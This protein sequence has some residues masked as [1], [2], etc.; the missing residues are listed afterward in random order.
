M[1]EYDI[2]GLLM[3][4]SSQ[5]CEREDNVIT[6]DLRGICYWK[7]ITFGKA[8]LIRNR[9][10]G[11]FLENKAPK[12]WEFCIRSS[13]FSKNT[14]HGIWKA[15]VSKT[16]SNVLERNKYIHSSG[17]VFGPLEFSRRD[18]MAL[19]IQRGRDHGLPDYNTVREAYGLDRIEK[20]TDINPNLA[21]QKPGVSVV[22]QRFFC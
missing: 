22:T 10:K 2:D 17:D 7:L 11:G 4:M 3:G 18:L 12:H 19:N 14:K 21:F 5:V 6:P 9:K 16:L 13:L 15:E 8:K 1:T 20:F